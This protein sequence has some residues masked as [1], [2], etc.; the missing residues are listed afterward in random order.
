MA[1]FQ[2]TAD[3]IESNV[4]K[5]TEITSA[6]TDVEYPSAAAVYDLCTAVKSIAQGGTGATTAAGALTNLLLND[7]RANAIAQYST[8]SVLDC[9][10]DNFSNF[11]SGKVFVHYLNCGGTVSAVWGYRAGD[12]G[13]F[14]KIDYSTE[15]IVLYRNLNGTWY[16]K[17]IT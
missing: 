2:G 7:L 11:I 1:I 10:K 12:Y 9:L 8:T 17:N 6:S 3:Q 16:E 13:A 5:V 14:L 4:N 15:N